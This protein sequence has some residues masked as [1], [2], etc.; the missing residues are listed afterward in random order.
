MI[1]GDRIDR[2]SWNGQLVHQLQWTGLDWTVTVEHAA[3]PLTDSN[4]CL[5]PG[6]LIC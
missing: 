1:D 4:L 5:N 6:F 2:G 3:F